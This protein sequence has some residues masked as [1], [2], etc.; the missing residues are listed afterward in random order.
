MPLKYEFR[1]RSPVTK[2]HEAD[3]DLLGVDIR[4]IG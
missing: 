3:G 2:F 1:G 4:F